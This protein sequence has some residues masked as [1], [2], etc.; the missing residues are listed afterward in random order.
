MTGRSGRPDLVIGFP[1][2]LAQRK[3]SHERATY[4]RL[5]RGRRGRGSGVSRLHL[6]VQAGDELLGQLLAR[7]HLPLPG[8]RGLHAVRLR[9][10]HGRWPDDLGRGPR[11]G[12]AASGRPRL[13]RGRVA[14]S[15]LRWDLPVDP[16]TVGSPLGVDGRVDLHAGVGG[17]HFQ[18]VL[19]CGPV[20]RDPVRYRALDEHHHP[21]CSR[22]HRP[23]DR[24]QLR[25]HASARQGGLL[26]L[27]RRTGR[28][29]RRG[30]GGCS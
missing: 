8:G 29:G 11:S 28:C 4:G 10:R 6:R 30:G 25:W 1:A 9:T 24:A 12:R 2:P 23:G 21:L 16:A 14:V 26:R 22:A 19:R 15:G 13:R 3:G 20:R 27:R 5:P 17:D 7:L 18:R